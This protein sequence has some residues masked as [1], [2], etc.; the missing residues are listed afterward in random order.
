MRQLEYRALLGG[1]LRAREVVRRTGGGA[2]A[3]RRC[4]GSAMPRC[5]SPPVSKIVPASRR[6]GA[7]ERFAARAAE[8]PLRP[9]RATWRETV[10]GGPSM[11]RSYRLVWKSPPDRRLGGV[12]LS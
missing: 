2:E 9:G 5:N 8:R 7:L 12:A 10:R 4:A 6:G 3:G 11:G 1:C